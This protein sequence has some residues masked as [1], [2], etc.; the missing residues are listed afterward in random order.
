MEN[1]I[2]NLELRSN[3]FI[4][5]AVFIVSFLESLALTGLFL[6]GTILMITLGTFIGNHKISL[7]SSWFIGIIGCLL[8]DWISYFIGVKLKKKSIEKLKFLNVSIIEKI[9]YYLN[10]YSIITIFLGK[11]IGPIRPLI[12]ILSGI[13]GVPIKKFF[14]PD[15]LGCILWPL[16]YF[17]PGIIAKTVSNIP[18]KDKGNFKLLIFSFILLLWCELYLFWKLFSNSKNNWFIKN[19]SKKNIIILIP[20]FLLFIIINIIFLNLSPQTIVLKNL[21]I[22]IFKLF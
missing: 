20:I 22:Q 2:N 17:I 12:P 10:N 14:Y 5:I 15:L 13:L 1:L 7:Y 3:Y 18:D 8:G 16:L 6:P 4:L 9:E 21:L 11:F 19:L